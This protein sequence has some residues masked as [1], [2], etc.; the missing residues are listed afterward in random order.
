VSRAVASLFI[1]N[2]FSAKKVAE[3][4]STHPDIDSRIKK[5]RSM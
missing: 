4:I 2:P 3:M 1:A 5:L